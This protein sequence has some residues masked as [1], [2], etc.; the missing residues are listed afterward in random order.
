VITVTP[1]ALARSSANP[2]VLSQGNHHERVVFSVKNTKANPPDIAQGQIRLQTLNLV[3][4]NPYARV[5]K[6]T[7][8]NNLADPSDDEVI[9]QNTSAPVSLGSGNDL[10]LSGPV[11]LNG[12]EDVPIE[13]QFLHNDATASDDLD[14]RGLSVTAS[15]AYE[16]VAYTLDNCGATMRIDVPLSPEASNVVQNKPVS[17]TSATTIVGVN[18][19]QKDDGVN[20]IAH[21]ADSANKGI[22][23]VVLYWV[24]T[25]QTVAAPPALGWT[26]QAMPAIGGGDY[27]LNPNPSPDTRIPAQN[28][29]RV[30]YYIL[31]TDNI[32]NF[33]RQP[34][35]DQGAFTYDQL[36]N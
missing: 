18:V 2:N 35:Y 33:D 24:A 17:P 14:M 19:V 22:A 23:S 7:I 10:P 28:G 11:T 25:N 29:K 20:V 3:Y 16:N 21:V 31:A 34:A 9:Y 27:L 6:V 12:Q 8:L 13:V 4:G 32:A 30:W 26:A 5:S 36:S 15:W 1:G